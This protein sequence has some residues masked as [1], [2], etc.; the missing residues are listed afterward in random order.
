MIKRLSII[1]ISII[2]LSNNVFAEAAIIYAPTKPV[3]I[4]E[5]ITTNNYDNYIPEEKGP[6]TSEVIGY[7][8]SSD[9]AMQ[10]YVNIYNLSEDSNGYLYIKLS[11]NQY[12]KNAW[13]KVNI[14]SFER[15][16]GNTEGFNNNYVWVYC[17]S[18]G[19]LLKASSG[20]M[21]IY[22][23]DNKAYAFNEYGQMIEGYFNDEGEIWDESNDSA[24]W[25]LLNG[26]NYLYYADK[27]GN[28]YS[29]WLQ[30][31]G[32]FTD[33]Y[34]WKNNIWFYFDP[35]NYKSIRAKNDYYKLQQIGS[36]KY[37]FDS[38]GVMLTGMDALKYKSDSDESI[39]Y[40]NSD[41]S[42]V[43]N[44][45]VKLNWDDEVVEENFSDYD[46]YDEDISIFL[47]KSGKMYKD[48]IKKINSSYYGFDDNGVVL[49]NCL[50]IFNNNNHFVD[51]VSIED[52]NGRS[53]ILNGKYT[54]KHGNKGTYTKNSGNLYYFDNSGKRQTSGTLN[55]DD[56]DY[57]WGASNTG[58]Y[59]D[60][61]QGY[62][63]IHGLALKADKDLKYGI[64]IQNPTKD[65]YSYNELY[66]LNDVYVINTSGKKVNG[67]SSTI[68]DSDDNY[69]RISSN[70]LFRGVYSVKVR[71]NEWYSY[72][73][74][75]K[76]EW[77]PIDQADG[78]GKHLDDYRVRLNN[79]Y[80]L[81]I[82]IRN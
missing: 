48:M 45:F 78:R 66:T 79:E 11:N 40:F 73:K 77:I 23:I 53:F 13:R 14:K 19:K 41:G 34:E 54:N 28:L 68:K 69:W 7:S 75:G 43:T 25:E 62:I 64:Y 1:L 33:D 74:N 63:Y 70:G 51:T 24:P 72:S 15:V 12:V 26:S 35:K 20:K 55:F 58:A 18:N 67:G 57:K 42:V 10:D 56:D 8:L 22:K 37:A 31:N 32:I 4:K 49:K 36:K 59:E 50:G 16:G 39:K 6:I 5:I 65:T 76:E 17:G 9:P 21:K 60:S 27:N 61:K 3:E 52:T 81:N 30:Y 82:N 47:N 71:S 29:G 80:G 44:G 2:L 46:D 38:N